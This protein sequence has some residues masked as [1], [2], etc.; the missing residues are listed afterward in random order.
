VIEIPISLCA[1]IINY[2]TTNAPSSTTVASTYATPS[3]PEVDEE[4]VAMIIGGLWDLPEGLD[5]VICKLI[6]SHINMYKLVIAY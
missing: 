3:I 6:I 1:D 2:S 5:K 4:S